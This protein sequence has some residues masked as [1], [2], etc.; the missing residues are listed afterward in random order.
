[1]SASGIAK[2]LMTLDL[3]PE[4][5]FHKRIAKDYE[6]NWPEIFEPAVVDP[7]VSF[8]AALGGSGTAL[9]FGIR[10]GRIAL[11]LGVLGRVPGWHAALARG[12]GHV[13]TAGSQTPP[14]RAGR[15]FT[16]RP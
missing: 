15:A 1:M 8:L 13:L 5:Y 16:G 14:D 2:R 11:I 7:A 9:E 3:R 10:T 6:A 4:N 12:D